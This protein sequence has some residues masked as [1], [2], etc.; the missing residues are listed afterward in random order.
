MDLSEKSDSIFRHPWELSRTHLI[1]NELD[2]MKIS[3]H[4]LDIGCGDAYFDHRLLEVFPQ[5]RELWGIDIYAK[6][7]I[8]SGKW[9]YVNSY[10]KISNKKFNCI[11]LM[12]VLEHIEDD[13]SF[14]CQLHEYLMKDTVLL[15]TVPAFQWLYS[16]HD[17]QLKHYRRYNY[18]MLNQTLQKAG[19]RINNYSYFYLSLILARMFSRNKTQNLGMWNR[20]ETNI[21]TKAIKNIL[22]ADYYVLRTLS[23]I[24]IHL[25]GLSLLAICQK[26]EKRK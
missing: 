19:Y 16:L 8:H 20:S 13:V 3:G 14:M 26:D 18:K 21:V 22:N 5:I 24:G 10:E 1:I 4:V 17:I 2:K 7:D 6:E 11:I 25:G 9:N 15:V 23:R 12:D